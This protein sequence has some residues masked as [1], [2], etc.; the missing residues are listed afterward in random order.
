MRFIPAL[1]RLA[2][3][4][5][6][7]ACGGGGGS[8]GENPIA[9]GIGGSGTISINIADAPIDG[10]VAAVVQF[11]GVALKRFGADESVFRFDPPLRID[12]LGLE[13]G[14]S[15]PLLAATSV[16]AGPYESM[17]L[18][19]DASRE[20]LD[21]HVTLPGGAQR[22]LYIP[23]GAEA[24]LRIA[25][26]FSVPPGDRGAQ[27]TL[28]FDL[29]RSVGAPASVLEPYPMAPSLRLVDNTTA[30][31]IE[32]SVGAGTLANASCPFPFNPALN[33]N[34]VYVFEGSNVAP[35]DIDRA[36]VEPVTTARLELNTFG[37]WTYRA[38]FLPAG[39]YT[40][41]FSCQGAS[42][43][44]NRNDN[45]VFLGTR[46]VVVNAAQATREDF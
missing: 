27:F 42:E 39:R 32:G 44:P 36:G 14:E 10:A 21:S 46:N 17:R 29:R 30:G 11:S 15:V 7:V 38:A 24:G 25:R 23:S 28:D 16:P 33:V 41:A 43:D 12:L 40:A 18:L 26:G 34:L 9:G 3:L 35:D 8:P 13:P 45:L 31:A 22:A 6:L 5:S 4:A 37:A 2:L 20:T 19:V 1:A